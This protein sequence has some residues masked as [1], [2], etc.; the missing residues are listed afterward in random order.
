MN[1]LDFKDCYN[2]TK[3]VLLKDSKHDLLIGIIFL[4]GFL[5][6]GW[7]GKEITFVFVGVAFFVL[8]LVKSFYV[9][10]KLPVVYEATLQ[11]KRR[12]VY[13]RT[14][15]VNNEEL[16]SY[17]YY[18][19]FTVHSA[20]TFNAF[21]LKEPNDTKEISFQIWDYEKFEKFEENDKV[22]VFASATGSLLAIKKGEEFISFEVF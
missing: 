8:F 1:S 6:W 15:V 2:K 20:G 18:L 16:V 13:S 22:F 14:K 3:P 10:R 9:K 19:D 12:V 7:Q 5:F 21:G 17:D 11:V 4:V